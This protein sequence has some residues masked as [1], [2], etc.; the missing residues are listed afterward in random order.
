MELR[1]VRIESDDVKRYLPV[2]GAAGVGVLAAQRPASAQAVDPITQM[3]DAVTAVTTAVN[4]AVPV[5][6]IVFGIGIAA[7]ALKRVFRSS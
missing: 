6:V 2:A 5:A 1:Q 3:T 7:L 4:E